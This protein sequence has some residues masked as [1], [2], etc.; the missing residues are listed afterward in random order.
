MSDNF[1]SGETPLSQMAWIVS[2][3]GYSDMVTWAPTIGAARW[4]W[5]SL[6]RD[7]YGNNR[8]WPSLSVARYPPLDGSHLPN[9]FKRR[10]IEFEEARRY[11]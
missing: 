6:W 2:C 7:A 9:G 8:Q 1:E 10:V 3:E 5:V 4:N 11:G